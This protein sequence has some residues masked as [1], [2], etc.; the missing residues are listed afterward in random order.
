MINSIILKIKNKRKELAVEGQPNG[1]LPLLKIIFAGAKRWLLARWYLRKCTSVGKMVT[2]N[3]KPVIDA[4]GTVH[5][6]ND[7]RIWSVFN[8]SKI[9]VSKGG[10]LKVGN[11]SR[12][13]GVHISVSKLVEIHDNVRIAP[14]CVIVDSDFHKVDDHFSND[15]VSK[16]IIIEDD[17]WITMRCMILRG[18]KI[19]RGA[20]IA[21]GAVVTKDVPPYTVVGGVPAKVIKYIGNDIQD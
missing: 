17:V 5:I 21:A 7:V 10:T 2:V 19:G 16:P 1:F 15:G 8:Q 13:N 12:I 6:G 3:G 18:V 9:Y 11:N 4:K 20:V 14:Y